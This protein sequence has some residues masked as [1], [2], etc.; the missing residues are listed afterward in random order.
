MK[1]VQDLTWKEK[2]KIMEDFYKEVEKKDPKLAEFWRLQ[3]LALRPDIIELSPEEIRK[4]KA[5]RMSVENEDD[6]DD[7]DDL[8]D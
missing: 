8:D 7:F 6:L 5:R 3:E 1:N 4:I 2:H